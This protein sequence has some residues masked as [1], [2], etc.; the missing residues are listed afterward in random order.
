MNVLEKIDTLDITLIENV[1]LETV[2]DFYSSCGSKHRI[3]EMMNAHEDFRN[4]LRSDV[5]F[6]QNPEEIRECAEVIIWIHE[7]AM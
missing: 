6:S 3:L 4:A 5:S 1:V 2:L 7:G